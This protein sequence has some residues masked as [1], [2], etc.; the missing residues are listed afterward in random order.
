MEDP[1]NQDLMIQNGI[2][3]NMHE[4]DCY[5][6]QSN[7]IDSGLYSYSD[8]DSQLNNI[9]AMEIRYLDHNEKIKLVHGSNENNE[10]NNILIEYIKYEDIKPNHHDLK[11]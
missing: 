6:T 3:I 11:S 10:L 9:N 5:R 1:D 2:Q 8:F 7:S 4:T